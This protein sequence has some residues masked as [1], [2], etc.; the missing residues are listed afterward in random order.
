MLDLPFNPPIQEL[1][2]EPFNKFGC[3]VF[4]QRDD[5]LHPFI[6]G[7]K[8]RK[9]K[10]VIHDAKE[11]QCHTLIS[12]GGAY[13]NH[14]IALACAGAT[15][16]FKTIGFVRG[17]EVNNQLLSL[18]KWYG[19]QLIF[20]SRDS[21]KNKQ[22]L[23]LDFIKQQQGF[24]FIDEGGKGELAVAGCEEILYK[25]EINFSHVLCAVGTGTTLA[26]LS[27]QAKRFGMKA[28]GVC[29]LKGE[30]L[31]DDEI[32]TIAGDV[33]HV[34]HGFHHGG[35]AKTS[36]EL[37]LFMQELAATT[38]VL[39]DQVYT[40]KLCFA[41]A[42]LIQQQYFPAHSKILLIH[43]GGLLGAMSMF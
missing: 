19:M 18:C 24:Y 17:E 42:A 35:Y 41:V 11:K 40:G 9:L 32:N 36:P 8:W 28:E 30:G 31:I 21:Y 14:L 29:V 27:K 33:V 25:T 16:G 15:Y 5:I 26:G 4:M 13:S 34:H 43:T 39:T 1:C 37:L 10:Y 22:Q 38:G 23:Y 3:K 6:S 7:N 2:F 20:T 12:F